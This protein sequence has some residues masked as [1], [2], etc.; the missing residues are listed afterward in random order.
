MEAGKK[1][2]AYKVT[3]GIMPDYT[4][5]GD[6]LHIDGVTEGRPADKAGILSGDVL[7][8]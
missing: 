6:G 8:P 1:V 3:L 4:D 5:Y 7:T 2:P